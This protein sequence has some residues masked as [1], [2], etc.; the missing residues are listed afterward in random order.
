MKLYYQILAIAFLIAVAACGKSTDNALAD[1]EIV[2]YNAGYPQ[3]ICH[4]GT[5]YCMMQNR[6][7]PNLIEIH[8]STSTDSISKGEKVLVFDGAENGMNHI[9][10]SELHLINGRWYVYFE[11]DD[12]NT[13]NH[14]LYVLENKNN[15]PMKGDWILHGPIIIDSE[16]NFGIHPSSVVVNGR[17]YLFWSGWLHR[18]AQ[19][20]TQC[21]FIAEMENPW[22]LKSKRQ[23]ISQPDYEW[24]RQ[25]INPDGSRTAYPI[26][27]NENPQ[28][29]LSPDGKKLIVAYSA[30]GIWT[31]Y[32]TL[33][34]IYTS[35]D[36]DLL[37]PEVWIKPKEPQFIQVSDTSHIFR[38]SN[39]CVIDNP[40]EN[41]ES[42]MLFEGK[43]NEDYGISSNIYKKSITWDENSLPVFGQP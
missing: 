36:S 7:N 39:I 29:F 42:I 33:G 31:E 35:T 34:M 28:P 8:A 19:T 3:I 2:F 24:E 43:K 22:T 21:I 25:W 40:T 5:Y 20:E 37:K 1:S 10:S 17:Q 38:V 4:D 13:D 15:D 32:N 27:V 12:G 9:W 26:F 30:S 23:L 14:Q 41:N 18:R 11:A 6:D 16:W